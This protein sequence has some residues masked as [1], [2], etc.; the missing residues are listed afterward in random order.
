MTK[1][2]RRIMHDRP[3]DDDPKRRHPKPPPTAEEREANRIAAR[4]F[5]V[6]KKR[7]VIVFPGRIGPGAINAA[8]ARN[9]FLGMDKREAA[10]LARDP[11]EISKL[12]FD[13]MER[14]WARE[15]FALM[16]KK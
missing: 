10:R 1:A 16:K 4:E 3:P 11:E 15:W 8:T 2:D 9:R 5:R 14:I 12:V 13:V 7:G 6:R